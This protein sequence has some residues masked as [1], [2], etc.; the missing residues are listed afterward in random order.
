MPPHDR[1]FKSLLRA[2]LPDLLRLVAPGVAARL[3]LS[4]LTFLDKELLAE[5]GRREADLIARIPLRK[6]GALVIHVEIEARARRAMPQRLRAYALRIQT[7]YDGQLLTILLNLRGG[8]AGIQRVRREGEIPGPGLS[9]FQYIVFG[10][11]GCAAADFLKR[12]EPLAWALAALMRSGS[13]SR[14]EHKLA[15]LRRIAAARLNRDRELLLMNFVEAYLVLTPEQA[16]EYKLLSARNPNREVRDMWMTWSETIEAKGRKEGIRL[17]REEG[18]EKGLEKGLQR[19][20]AQGKREGMRE[21][22][23]HLLAQRFG[24]LPDVVRSQV[25]A[26]TSTRRLTSL[27]GK[28]LTARSLR[29]LDFC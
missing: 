14:A 26:I 17:G 28:V 9:S 21:L 6:G 8:P 24:P 1:L 19:G 25:E 27:A 16:E 11:A 18:L 2:F 4:R 22:L 10:L 12:P 20:Q 5:G 3:R 7:L 23:L 15:C 29:D 13:M